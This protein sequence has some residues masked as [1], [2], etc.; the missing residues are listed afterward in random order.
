ML[1]RMDGIGS[2]ASGIKMMSN[3]TNGKGS[4]PRP[5]I[6]LKKFED[7]WDMIFK[8]KPQD[9]KDATNSDSKVQLPQPKER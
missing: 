1:T 8:K 5:V 4:R 2:L 7:N 3:P 9:K 6:D